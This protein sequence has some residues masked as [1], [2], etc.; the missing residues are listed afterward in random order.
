MRRGLDWIGRHELPVLMGL[1]VLML[2]RPLSPERG[3]VRPWLMAALA[4]LVL[5]AAISGW[6]QVARPMPA[7]PPAA[8][9]T[10]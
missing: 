10:P 1:L 5:G 3:M 9:A 7:E 8:S 4:V 6:A 2:A